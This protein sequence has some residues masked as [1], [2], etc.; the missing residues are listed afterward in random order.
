[1][2]GSS[3]DVFPW[4]PLRHQCPS[5][6]PSSR[7]GSRHVGS[8]FQLNSVSIRSSVSVCLCLSDA[9][10]CKIISDMCR[11]R[12]KTSTLILSGVKSI[13]VEHEYL[14]PRPQACFWMCC[15]RQAEDE[16]QSA[17]GCHG[18]SKARWQ[19]SWGHH[20]ANQNVMMCEWDWP[21]HHSISKEKGL[22][23]LHQHGK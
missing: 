6:F 16:C 1:M 7:F 4:P 3:C 12:L 9:L 14:N 10:R 19:V 20:A 22:D 21:S 8:G 18:D 13:C 15:G 2:L 11:L 23:P 17:I 5:N